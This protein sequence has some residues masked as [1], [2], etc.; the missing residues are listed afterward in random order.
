MIKQFEVCNIIQ[1]IIYLPK[2]NTWKIFTRHF[3]THNNNK[4]KENVNLEIKK[5]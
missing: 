2:N 5:H 1:R 3:V 4:E